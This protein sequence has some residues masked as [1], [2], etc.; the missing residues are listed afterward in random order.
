[1]LRRTRPGVRRTFQTPLVPWIPLAGIGFSLWLLSKL[2][3]AAWE[4]FIVW[5]ALG[6][7]LYFSYSRRHSVLAKAGSGQGE[8]SN[9]REL[10]PSREDQ[11]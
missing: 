10:R 1:M 4:R 2:P 5:M 7:L 6:L 3:A 9:G 8:L 11:L